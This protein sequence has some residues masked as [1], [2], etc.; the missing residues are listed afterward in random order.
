[1]ANSAKVQFT[2]RKQRIHDNVRKN[3][4]SH[5]VRL[6]VF[7]SNKHIYAQL[8][9]DSKGHTLAAVSTVSKDVAARLKNKNANIEAAKIVGAGIAEAAKKLN[10]TKVAFDKGPFKY[11]GVVKALAD[12]AR[13]MKNLE[14]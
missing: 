1:M 11:H 6:C 14:F 13:E 7:K 3:N 10:I 2:K 12:S 9:D 5:R 8:I 4:K